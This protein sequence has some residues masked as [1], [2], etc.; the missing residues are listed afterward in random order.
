MLFEARGMACFRRS[1]IEQGET[2]LILRSSPLGTRIRWP[3]ITVHASMGHVPNA[4]NPPGGISTRP[5]PPSDNR[6]FLCFLFFVL[7]A[8]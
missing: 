2:P 1:D 8:E 5:V 3:S 4:H 6:R 7:Q